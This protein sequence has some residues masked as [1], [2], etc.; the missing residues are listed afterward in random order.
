MKIFLSYSRRD[1]D[2]AQH[3]YEYFEG[4]GHSVLTDI[5]NIQVG[6]VWTDIIEDNISEC[7]VFAVLITF[8][9]IRSQEVE[10]EVLQAQ[11]KNKIIIPCI[12][13]EIKKDDL[14][15]N[16]SKIQGIEFDDKFELARRLY[17]RIE[18]FQKAKNTHIG[19]EVGLQQSKINKNKSNPDDRLKFY[20]DLCYELKGSK[21][22][23]SDQL[24]I[25]K[26]LMNLVEKDKRRKIK[27]I[28]QENLEYE[29]LFR[30][31]CPL[32][33]D[34]QRQEFTLIRKLTDRINKYNSSMYEL[35]DDK[36]NRKY[37]NEIPTLEDLFYHLS[38]WLAK[39]ESR[40]EDPCTPLIY[41]GVDQGR[42][43]PMGID[44]TVCEKVNELEHN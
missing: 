41:V 33:N 8:A 18:K 3:I 10:K 29:D 26:K 27:Y 4:S 13:I 32:L 31:L 42:P 23:F 20:S 39:Y 25:R 24:I 30:K 37:W 22:T 21:S 19:K 28:L 7:D 35:L 43:F 9:S 44:D 2:F 14:K 36:K 5:N 16:L 6:D 1:A 40:K 17:R 12:H 15:W 11:R 38:L 34:E